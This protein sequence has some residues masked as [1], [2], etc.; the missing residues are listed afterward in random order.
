MSIDEP[1]VWD[2]N[3]DFR[4]E[5]IRENT[6]VENN[7]FEGQ[8]SDPD[9]DS[10]QR[11]DE[12][13]SEGLNEE[14]ESDGNDDEIGPPRSPSPPLEPPPDHEDNDVEYDEEAAALAETLKNSAH[15]NVET[16]GRFQVE[17]AKAS[18]DDKEHTQMSEQMVDDIRHP[19]E[20][21]INDEVEEPGLSLS[22]QLYI[23]LGDSAEITYRRISKAITKRW[24]DANIISHH[25]VKKKVAELTG[26]QPIKHDM[27]VNSCIAY[28]GRYLYLDL[29]FINCFNKINNRS[30][31]R[32]D[33]VPKL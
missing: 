9:R 7:I 30:L 6:P 12:E 29:L 20:G 32:L 11:D 23:I 16:N 17:L 22:L 8:Q 21:P 19:P 1:I 26:I 4:A 24:P 14:N 3:D 2:N 15:D 27:C 5:E 13:P 10:Q 25:L 18:L 33:G 31:R 28:T